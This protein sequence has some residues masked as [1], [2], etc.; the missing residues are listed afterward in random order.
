M[1]KSRTARFI[2]ALVAL[3]VI[4]CRPVA[5]A[6]DAERPATSIKLRVSR[7]DAGT[8]VPMIDTGAMKQSGSRSVPPEL[9]RAWLE[10][11]HPRFALGASRLGRDEIIVVK[12]MWDHSAKTLQ[13][14]GINHRR[15]GEGELDDFDLR[16]T[17]LVI[18][19]CAGEIDRRACQKLRDFVARG[20]YL[21]STDWA[22]DNFLST[23][24]NEYVVW[25]KAVNSR[26]VYDATVTDADPVLM[27]YAVSHAPWKLDR[28]S[29]LI[30]VVNRD[31]VRVLVRSFDLAAEDPD[32]LG[33]L[34]VTFPFG[35]G[36]V[37]HMLGHF[38]NN[39]GI[40]FGNKLPDPAPVISISLRQALAANFVVAALN[41]IKIPDR[42]RN[43]NW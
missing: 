16:D 32:R 25:N 22:L 33:A 42:I 41:G 20:G 30:R 14:L 27:S 8:A 38:D 23:T 19:D 3:V 37:L 11:S 24:F 2:L 4:F 18:V 9:F 28:E 40:P 34:A 39:S 31:A 29:H 43:K 17:R 35:R 7:I 6:A 5:V 12:G 10:K 13:K 15:I 36:H 26:A 21:L 1:H